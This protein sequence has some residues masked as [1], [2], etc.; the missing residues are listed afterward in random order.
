MFLH[1]VSDPGVNVS[2]SF[3][4]SSLMV[5]PNKLECLSWARNMSNICKTKAFSGG[6]PYYTHSMYWK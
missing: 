4:S 1:H 5:W 3:F 2:K 6:T